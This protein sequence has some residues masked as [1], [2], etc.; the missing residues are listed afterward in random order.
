MK[1]GNTENIEIDGIRLQL[2]HPDKVLWP[3]EGITKRD[4][5]NYYRSIHMYILPYLKNRPMSLHRFPDGIKG[6]SFYQKNM[7]EVPEWVETV[8][9]FSKSTQETVHY[10][11]CNNEATLVYMANLACIEMHPWNSKFHS[12]D[13]PDWAVIDIDPGLHNNFDQVTDVA[14]AIKAILDKAEAPCFPKTSGA[15]GMHIY[16]PMGAKYSYEQVKNFALRVAEL[17]VEQLPN[18]TT[19]TR[20]PK[21]RGDHIYIDY[22]QNNKGQ[23]LASAYSVRP[24]PGVPV[25]TPLRWEEVKHGLLPTDFTIHNIQTRIQKSG[26]LFKG[27]LGNGIDLEKCLNI[28]RK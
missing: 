12:L 21:K 1:Y 3:Y 6:L 26:D 20:S 11:L 18:Q 5:I 9:V 8:P 22:L 15:T 14:L 25:S 16:I 27:V 4:L 19:T 28:L 7:Q 13:K 17:T 2:T 23:T 24:L 10:L